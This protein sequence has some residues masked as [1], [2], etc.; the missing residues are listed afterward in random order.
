MRSGIPE[1]VDD[2][3][4]GL[5]VGDRG[6]EFVVAIRR[7]SE[8]GGLWQQLSQAA[9]AR[10]VERQSIAATTA[11][12]VELLE[13]I[14]SDSPP[15]RAMAQPRNLRLPPVHPA[16]ASADHRRVTIPLPLRLLRGGRRWA[17]R[18]RRRL[19]AR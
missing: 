10:I 2:G 3:V 11:Q 19:F 9:R 6:D 18:M 13:V 8:D 17:G 12:W 16:L 14:A 5:L 4:T 15:P 7:L 1:L